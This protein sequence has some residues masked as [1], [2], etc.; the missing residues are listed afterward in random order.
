VAFLPLAPPAMPDEA[1][2]S[3]LAR[4]A[5]RYDVSA[6]GLVRHLLPNEPDAPGTI[7]RVDHVVVPALEAALGEATARPACSFAGQ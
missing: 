3:W 5:A 4:I 2:S 6:E 1:P 7:R